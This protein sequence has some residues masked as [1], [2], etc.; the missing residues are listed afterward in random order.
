MATQIENTLGICDGFEVLTSRGFVGWVEETWLDAHENPTA[1]ALRISDGRRGLMIADS[2]ED[3]VRERRSLLVS[4]DVRVLELEPPH[5]HAGGP[6]VATWRPT[7]EAIE[8]PEPPGPV[9]HAVL[10]RLHR[11]VV[12]TPAPSPGERPLWQILAILYS[13][14][15]VIA[16]TLV[17][18]DFLIAYFSTGRAY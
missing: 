18:V 4:S 15:G 10:D 7:G 11:P 16:L 3:C 6:L 13:C 8:L 5:I 14:L 12:P 2:V 1:F 17:G 9:H